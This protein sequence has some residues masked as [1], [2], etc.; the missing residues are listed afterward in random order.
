MTE[1]IQFTLQECHYENPTH[2]TC[3]KRSLEVVSLWPLPI[4]AAAGLCFSM[5]GE[6]AQEVSESQEEV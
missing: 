6:G 5:F 1:A 4:F 3:A 2:P